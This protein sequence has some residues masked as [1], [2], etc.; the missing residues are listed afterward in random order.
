MPD[1]VWIQ[2]VIFPMIGMGMAVL[3]MV[4]LYRTANRWLDRRHERALAEAGG[5]PRLLGEVEQLRERVEALEDAAL[6][7]QEFEERL[8][9]AERLLTQQRER[10]PL[11]AGE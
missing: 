8:D 10:P 1:F 11:R 4:G 2:N 6:K 7:V 9:F 3:A 5:N